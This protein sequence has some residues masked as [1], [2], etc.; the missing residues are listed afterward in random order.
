MEG[1]NDMARVQ[2]GLAALTTIVL[3][4]AWASTVAAADDKGIQAFV[5]KRCYTC[6]TIASKSAD[7]DKQKAAFMKASGVEA[8]AGDEGEDK[9]SAGGDLSGVG[10]EHDAEWIKKFLQDPKPHFK[11]DAD[12]QREA[13]K[14]DRKKL[15]A[16]SPELDA[17]VP[18][19]A[20]L[21]G[22]AKQAAGFKPCLKE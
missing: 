5:E 11:D 15:K 17:L 7:V 10:K 13:K 22:E 21:K 4:G 19:L 3:A 1:E 20:G 2:T 6:H 9:D 16:G 8:P 18:F 12:C 14:K